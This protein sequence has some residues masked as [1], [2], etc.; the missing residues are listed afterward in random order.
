MNKNIVD[1]CLAT[2]LKLQAEWSERT[3]GPGERTAGVL[4]HIRKEI[5]EIEEDPDDLEEWV[6][7][8]ILGFDGALRMGFTPTQIIEVIRAKQAKNERRTWPDWRTAEPGKAIEHIRETIS[9]D[10]YFV[11]RNS[12]GC[13]FVKA[14]RFFIDQGGL[15]E[16]WGQGWTKIKASSIE[17]ARRIGQEILFP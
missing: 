9:D 5:V 3:F 1:F 15:T 2:H 11:H 14:G 6:D 12:G 16:E 10:D 4:D 7:L 8:L 17:D 13:V